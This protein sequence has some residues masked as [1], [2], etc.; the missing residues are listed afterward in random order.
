MT[1]VDPGRWQPP[2]PKD[3]EPRKAIITRQKR[4]A[5]TDEQ[6][7]NA[8]RDIY[9]EENPICAYPKCGRPANQVHHIVRGT[10][11]KARSRKNPNTFL[12]ACSEKHHDLIEKMTPEKQIKLKLKTVRETIER[13]RK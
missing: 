4:K 6:E 13:L 12:G 9:L 8:V 5:M 2:N 3:I 11:G 1:R 10:A 7:Y